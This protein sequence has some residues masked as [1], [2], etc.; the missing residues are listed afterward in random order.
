MTEAKLNLSEEF[1][2]R[3]A[4]RLHL[5]QLQYRPDF[6]KLRVVLNDGKP[7]FRIA[8]VEPK[9]KQPKKAMAAATQAL[10][11]KSAPAPRARFQAELDAAHKGKMPKAPDFSAPSR[12]RY[13]A[14][15]ANI[16]AL[17]KAKDVAGLE[18]LALNTVDSSGRILARYRDHAVVALKAKA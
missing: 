6:E 11:E 12:K 10:P 2:T 13:R 9:A 15:L 16:V 18:A 4:A 7:G 1:K 14:K 3:L 5:E 17:V 8:F